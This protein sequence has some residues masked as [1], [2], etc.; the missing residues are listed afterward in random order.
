LSGIYDDVPDDPE[1]AFVFLEKA[2]AEDLNAELEREHREDPNID[3]R[4]TYMS[5]MIG[6]A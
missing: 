4:L 5:A 6:A 2:F 3:A 1:Q